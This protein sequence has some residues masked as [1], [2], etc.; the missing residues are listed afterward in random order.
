MSCFKRIHE[1]NQISVLDQKGRT[2]DVVKV[3]GRMVLPLSIE[4]PNAQQVG[5]P[6]RYFLCMGLGELVYLHEQ[7]PVS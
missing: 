7:V 5:C 3:A 4:I 2:V 1:L 6:D